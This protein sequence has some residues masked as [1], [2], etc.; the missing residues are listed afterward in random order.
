[1]RCKGKLAKKNFPIQSVS[2][3]TVNGISVRQNY[4]QFAR[5][6]V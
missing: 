1:M 6:D 2:V 3:V 4:N 5:K